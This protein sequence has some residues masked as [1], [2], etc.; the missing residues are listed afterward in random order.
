MR[1]TARY[2][3]AQ[4]QAHVG[5]PRGQF[6][7]ADRLIPLLQAAQDE[8]VMKVFT[9]ESVTGIKGVVVLPAVPAGTTSLAAYFDKPS[10]SAFGNTG[11]LAG[12]ISI[13]T[14]KERAAGSDDGQWVPMSPCLGDLPIIKT[15]ASDFNTVFKFLG[16]DILMPGSDQAEDFRIYGEF[17]PFQITGPDTPMIPRSEQIM[18]RLAAAF[19]VRPRNRVLYTDLMGEAVELM[20]DLFA[21][22][23]REAQE[24]DIHQIAN[25]GGSD[26]MFYL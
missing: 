24:A 8:L 3:V 15:A 10:T 22:L 2:A 11:Q 12:L 16:N 5:D 14:M 25:P 26:D 6:A 1:L 13:T 9:N 17:A 7:T 19:L 21:S 18:S 20:D 23:C 4:A